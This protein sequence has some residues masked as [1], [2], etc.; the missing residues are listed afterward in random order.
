MAPPTV[1]G[2]FEQ[3]VL[4]AVLRLGEQ[5]YGAA[6]ATELETTGG[7]EVSISAVHT[8]LDRLE[9]KGLAS[10]TRPFADGASRRIFA[11]TSLGARSLAL[12]RATRERL[13]SGVTLEPVPDT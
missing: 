7:R 6:I 13:W 8:T 5:A 11:V 4:L 12:T 9:A 1:L 2:D 3:I 10:S